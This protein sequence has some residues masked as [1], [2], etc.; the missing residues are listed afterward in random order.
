MPWT[1]KKRQR[2][3]LGASASGV[4]MDEFFN[5]ALTLLPSATTCDSDL[6]G[7]RQ[8][9]ARMCWTSQAILSDASLCASNPELAGMVRSIVVNS[10]R[11]GDEDQ[12]EQRLFFRVEG[13]LTNLIRMQSQKKIQLLTARLSVAAYRAQLP[14]TM[15]C[16]IHAFAPG[17]LAC[18]EWT[19]RFVEFAHEFRPPCSYE[20]LPLVG[21]TMFDNYSRKVLYKS[22]ATNDTAGYLL[23]MTNWASMTIPKLVAPANFDAHAN[24]DA[25]IAQIA[26]PVYIQAA[27]SC[28]K[29]P[30]TNTWGT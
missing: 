20:E 9:L 5:R 28:Y 1:W 14:E 4:E 7:E 11:P 6:D 25:R 29:L 19:K 8:R 10:Y 18:P 15:W 12:Y 2:A 16:L 27:T 30:C 3:N 22:Q 17:L 26:L 23:N 13:L 24:C 21:G